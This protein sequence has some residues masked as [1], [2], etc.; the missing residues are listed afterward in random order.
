VHFRVLGS[1]CIHVICRCVGRPHSGVCCMCLGTVDCC[2]LT[3]IAFRKRGKGVRSIYSTLPSALVARGS[4]GLMVSSLSPSSSLRVCRVSNCVDC[5][6]S[7]Q[8][9]VITHKLCRPCAVRVQSSQCTVITHKLCRLCAVV[10]V[11][12]HHS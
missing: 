12:C 5:V 8:C 6:Q 11:H 7:S 9:T 1:L 4:V 3:I 10:T 2:F